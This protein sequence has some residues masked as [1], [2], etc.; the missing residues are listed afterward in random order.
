MN[1]RNYSLAALL[2]LGFSSGL[3][4]ALSGASLQ[5]WLTVEGVDLKT[6]GLLAIAGTPYTFKFLWAPLLDRYYPRFAD[7]R[8][9]WL[10]MTQLTLGLAL[11]ALAAVGV[12]TPLLVGLLACAIAASSATQDIAFDAY[13]TELLPSKDRGLGAAWSVFGYRLAM[14]VSGGL[15]LIMADQWLGW[16][17]TYTI[18]GLLMLGLA[19]F[20]L[21]APALPTRTHAPGSIWAA[22][23][24]AWTD[25]SG[26]KGA[27]WLLLLII[28]YKLGD[29]F[30]GSLSTSFLIR[31]V[32]FTPTE[33]GLMNKALG[34]AATIGGALL[35]GTI[36]ARIGLYRALVAFGILQAA[37]N[38]CF[39]YLSISA[40]S[41]WTLG[42]AV[43]IE[44]LC[45]GMGTA[46]FVA[47]LTGLCSAQFS[48]TQYALLSALA[49]FGRVYL[50]AP[51]GYVV[52][53]IGWT[54]FFMVSV[55]LAL[56]G[57][58]MLV[59]MR[60]EVRLIDQS[61]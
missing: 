28:L 4:L 37:S 31:G 17:S 7:H 42:L 34:L 12:Q 43:G 9:S 61:S 5:A 35:G 45:G 14:L 50:T 22:V 59:I 18:M 29:A 47:L 38:L 3:P 1:R 56:P 39:W 33:V 16:R 26:R 49:S 60:Q 51:S 10:F 20:T 25:Y 58:I 6:I 30:A 27:M 52:E 57:L 19:C 11:F 46:A 48:A 41:M 40:K 8:R 54:S 13:R 23:S 24:S 2:L 21:I 32:G 44:N 15:A 53:H 55:G 36:L